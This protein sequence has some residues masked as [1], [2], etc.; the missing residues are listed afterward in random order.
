MLG[1]TVAWL[2]APPSIMVGMTAIGVG[3][4]VP[5]AETLQRVCSFDFTHAGWRLGIILPGLSCLAFAWLV[6]IIRGSMNL[7][8]EIRTRREAEERAALLAR[9]DPLTGLPNRRV[10]VE[11][12]RQL[13]GGSEAAGDCAV[14]F[15]DLD[16]FKTIN[17]VHGH[18]LGDRL[19]TEVAGRLASLLPVQGMLAR[20]GGDEFAILPG[21]MVGRTE[22]VGLAERIVTATAEPFLVDGTRLE[23]GASIGVAIGPE[24]GRDISALLRAADIAMYCAKESGR[25]TFRFFEPE[26]DAELQE[27]AALK[28]ELPIALQEGQVV[29][30][31]QPL[32]ELS[33]GDIKGFEL[34]AR[35]EHPRLGIVPPDRFVPVAEDM[36]VIDA[37]SD[38]LL[39]QACADAKHWPAHLRM[40]VNIAPMQ[41][42]DPNLAARIAG[43]LAETGFAPHRLEIEITESALVSDPE[44]AA[45]VVASLKAVGIT[46]ALDN[47]GTGY[48]SLYHL[49]QIDLDKIKIDRS[50]VLSLGTE[51]GSQKF[52]EAIIGLGRS[53]G[54]Q[55]AAEGIEDA[56]L[57]SRLTT[58]GCNLGQ[59]YLYGQP[60]PAHAFGALIGT[61]RVAA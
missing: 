8:A 50:F 40:S 38:S 53:L 3:F 21:P 39:R 27:K 4:V 54:L 49:R 35:W 10:F 25:S 41:L 15:V 47:F 37:L 18:G 30:W 45:E 36:N 13:L 42:K 19:L 20:L 1:R 22:L 14:M 60:M 57:V 59:G 9:H 56:S 55:T 11:T 44:S 61:P 29:P 31:F 32:A 2:T 33:T 5:G 12:A 24:D 48:S 26:M 16:G 17:D 52:V 23:I 7:R 34:L 58:L 6:L 46:I 51:G 28:A 43:I